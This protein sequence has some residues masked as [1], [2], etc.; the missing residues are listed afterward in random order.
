LL[1]NAKS[2]SFKVIYFLAH[3][4]IAREVAHQ[5][6]IVDELQKYNKQIIIN[7]E[8]YVNKPD[9]KLSLTV[10]G[11][12]ADFERAKIMERMRRGNT[13]GRDRLKRCHNSQVATH[14]LE[15]K[16]FE[17]IRG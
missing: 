2:D 10:F 12:V 16:V 5:I 11:A 4:R 14:L 6:L 9:E 8:E 3:D 1:E 15:D 17:M 13:H 7:A